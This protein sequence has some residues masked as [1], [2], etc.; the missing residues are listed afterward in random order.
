VTSRD[1]KAPRMQGFP[2]SAPE[3]SRTSDL[4]FRSGHVVGT[5]GLGG[6]PP[7]CDA[8]VAVWGASAM[9]RDPFTAWFCAWSGAAQSCPF[10]S[11]VSV[12][13]TRRACP[14]LPAEPAYPAHQRSGPEAAKEEPVRAERSDR[15]DSQR[16]AELRVLLSRGRR[17]RGAGAPAAAGVVL[18]APSAEVGDGRESEAQAGCG[19][20]MA[21]EAA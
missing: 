12:V 14:A 4:V 7:G 9:V 18:G 19:G 8:S 20:T 15:L 21:R 6:R 13:C 3:R 2:W 10:R 1:E 16:P 11:R 17:A 5:R